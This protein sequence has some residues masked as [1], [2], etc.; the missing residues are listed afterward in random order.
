M[1]CAIFEDDAEAQVDHEPDV[2]AGRYSTSYG[3]GLHEMSLVCRLFRQ[4]TLPYIY[5]V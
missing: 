4:L 2:A 1:T 5:E 3:R